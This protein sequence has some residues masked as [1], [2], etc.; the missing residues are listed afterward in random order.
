M[1]NTNELRPLALPVKKFFNSWVNF[2]E[3]TQQ[4]LTFSLR[5][6]LVFFNG[7]VKKATP[8]TAELVAQIPN[9][10]EPY[11]SAGGSVSFIGNG[12]TSLEHAAFG[13]VDNGSNPATLSLYKIGSHTPFVLDFCNFY[14]AN[15]RISGIYSAELAETCDKVSVIVPKNINATSLSKVCFYF[16]GAG[17]NY[18]S[19]LTGADGGTSDVLRSVLL[20]LIDDGWIVVSSN[21][22]S[23]TNHWGNPASS[24]ATSTVLAW[25]KDKFNITK[26]VAV[27]QSMGGLSSL[28]AL[29]LNPDI[30]N[31][32]GIYPVCNLESS[33][34]NPIF[35]ADVLA[36]HGGQSAYDANKSSC[37]P[38][39]MSASLFAGKKMRS[40]ASYADSLVPRA[41]H[42]DLL[43]T[44][45]IGVVTMQVDS[46]V[47]AHGHASA[48]I[49]ADVIAHLNS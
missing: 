7:R 30:T 23:I 49:P 22:G 1:I 2:D 34:L 19:H 41:S 47:D 27:G 45:L 46:H 17:D 11:R 33:K 4:A 9:G 18:I 28:R 42:S 5:D 31:W 32:Y 38:M 29:S 36:A 44:R 20:A 24:L 40:I 25:L 6:G 35:S 43:K 37:D 10:Y 26:T 16:H 12:A 21:G 8:A 13:A 3:N 14:K 39:L 48:F 15:P